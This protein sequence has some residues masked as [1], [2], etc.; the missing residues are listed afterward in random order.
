MDA[1]DSH[2]D[3]KSLAPFESIVI[4]EIAKPL[5]EWGVECYV[6]ATRA[7]SRARR[8][9][10]KAY[11]P[12]ILQKRS[13]KVFALPCKLLRGR[14]AIDKNRAFLSLLLRFSDPFKNRFFLRNR[15]Y[16]TI[17]I[18]SPLKYCSDSL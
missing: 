6:P 8:P 5:R 10:K 12:W 18:F 2:G 11:Y 14:N 13:T 9:N 4:V 3:R 17:Y 1:A 7:R 16:F 15:L